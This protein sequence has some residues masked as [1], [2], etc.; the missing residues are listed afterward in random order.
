[1]AM[2]ADSRQR[3]SNA[4]THLR[5]S[6]RPCAGPVNARRPGTL[7]PRRLNSPP[8]AAPGRWPPGRA[9]SSRQPAPARGAPGAP[10]WKP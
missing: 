10:A 5:N 9:T 4:P 6:G 8:A 1:V 2:L 3:C 7:L